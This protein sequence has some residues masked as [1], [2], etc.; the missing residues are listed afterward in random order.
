MIPSEAEM[1]EVCNCVRKCSN[2]ALPLEQRL[3]PESHAM[4][5]RYR[6]KYDELRVEIPFTESE[7]LAL[8]YLLPRVREH[9][10][11]LASVVD[12]SLASV[13]RKVVAGLD[14]MGKIRSGIAGEP[15]GG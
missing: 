14:G 6:M 7:L 15:A 1:M 2:D 5:C 3:K 8:G 13:E 9:L 11:S 10:P 12:V 4:D